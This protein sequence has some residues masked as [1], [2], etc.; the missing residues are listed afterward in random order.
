MEGATKVLLSLRSVIDEDYIVLLLF[1]LK[2]WTFINMYTHFYLFKGD[3][4]A[5]NDLENVLR[6]MGIE[7]AD[8]EFTKAV[9]TLP[10]SGKPKNCCWNVPNK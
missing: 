5:I 2:F 4:V 8:T 3:K 10:V 6:N 9:R 7:L 1:N